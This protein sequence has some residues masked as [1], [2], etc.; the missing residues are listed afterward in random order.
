MNYLM[1]NEKQKANEGLNKGLLHTQ[2]W[3][4]GLQNVRNGLCP[5]DIYSLVG[6]TR[7]MYIKQLGNTRHCGVIPNPRV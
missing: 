1:F 2:P 4:E 6:E 7:L 5:L 3:A